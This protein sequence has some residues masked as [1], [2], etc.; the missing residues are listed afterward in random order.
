MK[1]KTL[2]LSV[3]VLAL[4]M[5]AM[6][7]C[8]SSS[9][10][11]VSNDDKSV[12]ITAENAGPDDEALSGTLVIGEDEQVTIDSNLEKGGLQIEF[13]KN[14]GEQSDEDTPD[15]DAEPTYTANV[16]EVESQA[17]QFGAGTFMVK[18]TPAEKATGT[19]EILVKGFD[20]E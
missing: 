12:T 10:A 8:S 2:L 6:V 9:L 18:V 5:I 16:S 20:G 13:I 1:K 19:V 15:M 11:V 7:S 14:E 3:L 4:A 17:V